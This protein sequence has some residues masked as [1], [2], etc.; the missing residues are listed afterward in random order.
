MKSY[1]ISSCLHT[2]LNESLHP[3][4]ENA[5]RGPINTDDGNVNM[6][7]HDENLY[8]VFFQNYK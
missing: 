1:K 3:R 5:F 7:S 4:R 2:R 6:S 8:S